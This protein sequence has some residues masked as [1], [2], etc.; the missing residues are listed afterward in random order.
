MKRST[1]FAAVVVAGLGL[2]AL[3]QGTTGCSVS[4]QV[5]SV[6]MGLDGQGDRPRDTFYPDTQTIFCDV[7]WVGRDPDTTVNA[8]IHQHRAEQPI[9]AGTGALQQVEYEWAVGE[10][11]GGEKKSIIGFAWT[12]QGPTGPAPFPVGE[13]TCDIVVNGVPSGSTKFFI[14]YPG[15]QKTDPSSCGGAGTDCPLGGAATPGAICLGIYKDQ[16][17]CPSLN[18]ATTN[19]ACTCNANGDGLWACTP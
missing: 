11:V 1:R 2:V 6:F 10:A 15:C 16:A 13:Y 17:Q 4:S 14:T 18:H 8:I 19:D 5:N 7:D 12:L 3:T 9:Y